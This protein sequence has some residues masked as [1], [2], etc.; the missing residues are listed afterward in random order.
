VTL[1]SLLLHFCELVLVIKQFEVSI[2]EALSLQVELL[3]NL[4]VECLD[5]HLKIANDRVLV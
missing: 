2:E 3:L 1:F 4:H 5:F